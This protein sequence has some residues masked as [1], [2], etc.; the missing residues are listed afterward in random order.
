MDVEGVSARRALRPPG[1]GE[2]LPRDDRA[3]PVEECLRQA[4]LYWR[5]GYSRAAKCQHLGVEDGARRG[6]R[7]RPLQEHGGA[8]THVG[9]RRGQTYPVLEAVPDGRRRRIR[10]DYEQTGCALGRELHTADVLIGPAD[11]RH[12]HGR[13]VRD[14]RCG[15]VSC[16]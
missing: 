13:N 3:Q 9:I 10:C 4:G 16:R 7:L 11:Q 2:R 12:V 5:K 15:L 8:C 6:V 14:Q 1:G